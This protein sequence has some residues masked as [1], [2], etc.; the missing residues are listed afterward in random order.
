[1]IRL[2]KPLEKTI[3]DELNQHSKPVL[4]NKNVGPVY[5]LNNPHKKFLINAEKEL[6]KRRLINKQ[7]KEM[8][9]F[10][11][12]TDLKTN[13]IPKVGKSPRHIM[14]NFRPATKPLFD[15]R[16]PIEEVLKG[17]CSNLWDEFIAE[18]DLQDKKTENKENMPLKS[19][20]KT[21]T[22]AENESKEKLPADDASEG[23]F[24]GEEQFK[25]SLKQVL[26]Q[27][28]PNSEFQF[29]NSE[30]DNSAKKNVSAVNEADNEKKEITKDKTVETEKKSSNNET[31]HQTDKEYDRCSP[32]PLTT[33]AA[34]TALANPEFMNIT[35]TAP[36]T[37]SLPSTPVT[38]SRH[39][40]PE[41]SNISLPD[42]ITMEDEKRAIKCNQTHQ[43]S[44]VLSILE[45]MGL[46]N[47][48]GWL[49]KL[50]EAKHGDI[51][52]VL[53]TLTPTKSA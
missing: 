1:M 12:T 28:F 16:L 51:E 33:L 23:H 29:V 14:K 4:E 11:M 21:I 25:E 46:S 15:T 7:L 5:L 44:D 53:Q 26:A 9:L 22:Q 52:K 2:A 47:D 17:S 49:T 41:S 18:K 3:D 35:T 8:P 13:L 10:H 45:A 40:S 42:N 38:K 6:T 37:Q 34:L 43:T 31:I 20:P 19:A 36:S 48:E 39:N 30:L 27:I 24:V 50:V 32:V